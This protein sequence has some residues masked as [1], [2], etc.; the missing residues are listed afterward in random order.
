MQLR[1]SDRGSQ[2]TAADYRELQAQHGIVVNMSG[3]GDCYDNALMESFFSTLKAECVDRCDFQTPQQARACIFEYLE[4][5][6]NRQRLHSTLGYLTPAEYEGCLVAAA[7][8][9][10]CCCLSFRGRS[11]LR[12]G[13]S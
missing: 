6:Y 1:L 13:R 10:L 4:V 12:E 7:R 3:K 2:Y 9:A 5:F 11:I 8:A